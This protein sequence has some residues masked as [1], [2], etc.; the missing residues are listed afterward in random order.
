ME[1]SAGSASDDWKV[2]DV[3]KPKEK[4][5]KVALKWAKLLKKYWGI[6]RLQWIF[7]GTGS[8]LNELVSKECRDR[9]FRTYRIKK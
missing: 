6:K 4:E 2:V 9:L 7:H 8:Y 1:R 5:E 3:E